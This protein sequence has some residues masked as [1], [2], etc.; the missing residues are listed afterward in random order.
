MS[1]SLTHNA[2]PS[3][4]NPL[5]PENQW[6]LYKEQSSQNR[7]SPLKEIVL[8]NSTAAFHSA[9]QPTTSTSKALTNCT[10]ITPTQAPKSCW[11]EE[12]KSQPAVIS[13]PNSNSISE[14]PSDENTPQYYSNLHFIIKAARVQTAIPST[15]K[16][17]Q[18]KLSSMPARPLSP[19]PAW[20]G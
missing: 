2:A 10:K 9:V 4:S 3:Q 19:I 6:A 20:N 5:T 13:K 17:V 7:R 16:A 1:V 14:L 18:L 11:A 12:Q 8:Q 15:R